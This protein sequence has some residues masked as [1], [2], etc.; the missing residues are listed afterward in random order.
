MKNISLNFFGEQVTIDVPTNLTSL[1]KEIADKFMFSPSDAAEIVLS[2]MKDL[3]KIDSVTNNGDGTYTIVYKSNDNEGNIYTFIANENGKIE[4]TEVAKMYTK[5]YK[6]IAID[7]YQDSN[8]VQ[9][10]ILNSISK[11][12]NMFMVGDVKQ[13]IY[14]CLYACLG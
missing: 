5:K 11:G 14:K 7:E 1:R 6:E 4:K 10:Y 9:E 3:A 8:L 12:N 2:Y 13:S